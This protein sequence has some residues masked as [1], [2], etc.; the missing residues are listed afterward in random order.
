MV[1]LIIHIPLI[2][3]VPSLTEQHHCEEDGLPRQQGDFQQPPSVTFS[4]FRVSTVTPLPYHHAYHAE[5][6]ACKVDGQAKQSAHGKD[7]GG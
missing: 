3:S 5:H 7:H 4:L 6:N 1:P 2:P